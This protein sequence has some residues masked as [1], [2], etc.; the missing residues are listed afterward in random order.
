MIRKLSLY[1]LALA[2]LLTSSVSAK[3]VVSI[4]AGM[5][6]SGFIDGFPSR[7]HTPEGMTIDALSGKI[8][9]ADRRNHRIRVLNTDGTVATVAGTGTSGNTD[10]P[11][12]T[13]LFDNPDD[14]ILDLAGNLIV[15]ERGNDRIRKIDLTAGTVSTVAGTTAG[16]LDDAN[17]LTAQFNNP[18]GLAVDAS[19][20]IYVADHANS[21][22]RKIDATT[23]AVTTF[24]GSN[25]GFR[26]DVDPLQA[27][28]NRPVDL[29]FNN[30][31]T[32]LYVTEDSNRRIRQ[33]N[34]ATGEVSTFAGS[35]RGYLDHVDPLQ[36]QFQ[37]LHSL[38]VAS[39]DDIYVSDRSGNKIRKIN[40]TT[41]EVTTV[42]G[43]SGVGG[44]LD[45]DL[46]HA[47]FRNPSGIV[48][49]SAGDILVASRSNH[50]IRK[51]HDQEAVVITVPGSAGNTAPEVIVINDL[52]AQLNAAGEFQTLPEQRI[53]LQAIA[54][55]FEDGSAINNSIA[56]F[57][58]LDGIVGQGNRLNL[59]TLSIGKHTVSVNATDSQGAGK[60]KTIIINVVNNVD[61]LDLSDELKAQIAEDIQ[62]E[63]NVSNFTGEVTVEIPDLRAVKSRF[64]KFK[65]RATITRLNASIP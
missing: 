50:T 61:D 39:N 64:R 8:Y 15:S 58:D 41:G 17:P 2:C 40:G 19:G 21:K 14:V 27:R 30:A 44:F 6:R 18:Y 47:L 29:A 26:N 54:F 22:I 62:R 3:K 57:S 11:I 1:T 48:V 24:A 43:A 56:W 23:G 55:D 10:G 31:K 13:A 51:I 46:E 34:M 32:I 45:G 52:S 63:I 33:I 12:A 7:L 49:D 9:F 35:S 16:F 60:R 65:Y 59:A 4:V 37:S 28:F 36:A 5:V 20:N 53:T 42:A 25:R 38:F